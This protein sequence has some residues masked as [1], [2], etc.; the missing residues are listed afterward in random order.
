MN[1]L[2]LKRLNI[3]TYLKLK[4]VVTTLTNIYNKSKYKKEAENSRDLIKWKYLSNVS[5]YNSVF[6]KLAKIGDQRTVEHLFGL[7][8]SSDVEPNLDS[9]ALCLLS[10]SKDSVKKARHMASVRLRILNDVNRKVI[11]WQSYF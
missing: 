5:I 4:K 6:H 11:R 3:L 8:R 10:T 7:M 9:F 2:I 1:R